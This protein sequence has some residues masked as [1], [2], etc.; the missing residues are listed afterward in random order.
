MKRAEPE[1]SS[2]RAAAAFV[3]DVLSSERGQEELF[4]SLSLAEETTPLSAA[5]AGQRSR[6]LQGLFKGLFDSK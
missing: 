5:L 2:H 3:S 1:R 4:C 6:H